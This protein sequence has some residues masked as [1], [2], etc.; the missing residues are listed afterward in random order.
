MLK[1]VNEPDWSSM[2]IRK[3]VVLETVVS[4]ASIPDERQPVA[5][6]KCQSC[7]FIRILVC[8]FVFQ[9]KSY[10]VAYS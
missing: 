3:E 6:W 9:E 4:L 10:V 2:E 8:L 5:R 1:C 7:V